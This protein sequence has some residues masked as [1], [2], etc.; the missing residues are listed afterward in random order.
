MVTIR[1]L[2]MFTRLAETRNMSQA[3]RMLDLTQPALSQQLR[4][5]EDRLGLK[6]FERVPK[7]MQP[8]PKGR[9]LL[10]SARAALNAVRDFGDAADHAAL[11][12]AGSIRFGV[13]PTIGPYLMPTVIKILHER[14][15][16]LR[17]FMREGI[18]AVQHLGLA[19]G[20]LDMV[21]SPLPVTG[22]GVHV[23]PLFREPLRLVAPPDDPLLSQQALSAR[24]FAGRTFLTLDRQ[25]HY[26]AQLKSICEKLDASM[27]AD[28]EGTSLDAL[29]Q[30]AGSGVGLAVLPELY[31]RSA[32]GGL[33]VVKIAEPTEWYEYR[34]IGAAW[35]SSA[36][37]ADLFAEIAGIIAQEA[38]K[39]LG[40]DA[41]E[42]V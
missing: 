2:E 40:Q 17:L 12:S 7:G 3:A 24:D 10:T 20:E 22:R 38:R 4:A 27:L 30:M 8:T 36:A 13:S 6:L 39:R 1:Q 34:S 25:H 31:I 35:R 11:R 9:E 33:D 41:G 28:Y 26:H 42:T 29:Q 19:S 21:L 37:F 5:L 23:E 32:A 18:P 15:P 16:N 14:H